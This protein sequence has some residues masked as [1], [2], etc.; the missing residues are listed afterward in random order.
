MKEFLS[1]FSSNVLRP[2][3]SLLIPGSIAAA[4]TLTALLWANPRLKDLLA[5]APTEATV[6]AILVVMFFGLLCEDFGSHVEY[7]FDCRLNK[8]CK[9]AD[10]LRWKAVHDENWHECLR[11]AYRIEPVGQHHLRPLVRVLKFEL[12]SFAAFLLALVGIWFLPTTWT[13]WAQISGIPVVFAGLLYVE[14]KWTHQI[15]SK[16]RDGLLKGE[17]EWLPA[18]TFSS[19]SPTIGLVS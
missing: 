3:V 12:G 16:L 10:N 8:P 6:A 18:P 2:I 4:P 7:W 13:T 1:A 5:S 17:H 19:I 14:A 9:K 11:I 15:L